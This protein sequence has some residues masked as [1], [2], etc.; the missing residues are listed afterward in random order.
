VS[1][2]FGVSPA[3]DVSGGF[4]VSLAPDVSGGFGVSLNPGGGMGG[5]GYRSRSADAAR[6]SL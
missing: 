3:P 4:G 1:G 2:G 6:T 5:R